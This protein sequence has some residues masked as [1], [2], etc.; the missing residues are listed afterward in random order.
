MLPNPL[1]FLFPRRC[2]GCGKISGY[3][4]S[5]CLEEIKPLQYQVCPVC[6]RPAINGLAH[7]RCQT[8]FSLDG[9]TSIFPYEEAIKKAIGKLKYHFV[10]DLAEDLINLAA[11]YLASARHPYLLRSHPIVIPVPLHPRRER[12]RGFNQAELLGK[13]LAGY[14]YWQFC[15]NILVRH[16]HTKPQIGLKGAKR[17]E[18]IADAFSV[19]P[20]FPKIYHLPSNIL[21]FDDVWTTGSTLKECGKVLKRVG[22][23]KVWGLTLAR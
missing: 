2:L 23:K 1:D 11:K 19:N 15:D 10:T 16:K 6:E 9:L 21:L 3:F 20:Q 5:S 17:K 13:M 7:F 14:F 18:N 8:R 12:W 4:C 22:A